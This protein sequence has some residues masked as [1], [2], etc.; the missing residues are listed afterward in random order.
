[1]EEEGKKWIS[2]WKHTWMSEWVAWLSVPGWVTRKE[3]YK[4]KWASTLNDETN[5]SFW[6]KGGPL[7]GFIWVHLLSG[8][9]GTHPYDPSLFTH[10]PLH[11]HIPLCLPPMI[12]TQPRHI[13]AGIIMTAVTMAALSSSECVG[14]RGNLS[15]CE[16]AGSKKMKTNK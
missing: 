4:T 13:M 11:C 16:T 15:T 6:H 5:R 10:P 8:R 1:M 12:P 2:E 9:L 7:I 14:H 3:G